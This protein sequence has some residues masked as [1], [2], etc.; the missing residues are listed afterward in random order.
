MENKRVVRL[1]LLRFQLYCELFHQPGDN[2]DNVFDWEERCPEQEL[3][4]LRYEWWEVE[5]V[6]SIYQTLVFCLENASRETS[7]S[8][9]QSEQTGKPLANPN[10]QRGLTQ[11]RCFLDDSVGRATAFGKSYLRRFLARAFHG[12]GQVDREDYGYFSLPRP[13]C[14][15]HFLAAGVQPEGTYRILYHKHQSHQYIVFRG[16]GRN[17][18]W[19]PRSYPGVQLE[20]F[21]QRCVTDECARIF[22]G[23]KDRR[24]FIRLIRWVFWDGEALHDWLEFSKLFETFRLESGELDED[25][26]VPRGLYRRKPVRWADQHDYCDILWSGW[27]GHAPP[28]RECRIVIQGNQLQEVEFRKSQAEVEL[29]ETN[30]L[31]CLA[32]DKIHGTNFSLSR[33]M[34]YSKLEDFVH[35]IPST[36]S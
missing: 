10:Q 17:R 14:K 12:F 36:T 15:P 28:L 16:P 20:R 31:A 26:D 32:V 4:W 24:R 9:E 33:G 13:E 25:W 18:K 30:S 29:R 3:F 35:I 21:D 27:K 6:K 7:G 5:E 19:M 23:E 34:G 2:S 22:G 8:I 1:A 11:L